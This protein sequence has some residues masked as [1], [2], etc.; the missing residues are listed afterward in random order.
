MTSSDKGDYAAVKEYLSIKEFSHYSRI[1]QSTLRYWDDIGLFPPAMRGENN[2]YR[3]YSPQQI[4]GVNFISVLSDLDISLQKIKGIKKGRNPEKI[5]ELIAAHERLLDAEL[6]KLSEKYAIMHARKSL[7]NEGVKAGKNPDILV[8]H[9]EEMSYRKGPRNYFDNDGDFYESFMNYYQYAQEFQINLGFPVGGFHESIDSFILSPNN[10][11]Y[12]FSYDP[13]GN[14]VSPAGE[15]LVGLKRGFYGESDDLSERMLDYIREHDLQAKG[16]V[17]T[18]CLLDELC[19][20]DPSQLLSQV[21]V[22]IA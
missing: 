16:P 4:V 13:A 19:T 18:L 9:K 11:D 21:L 6:A 2:N 8:M 1:E 20:D 12:F 3:Y 7:I 10:P 14:I 17:F 22:A 15:Y 5:L